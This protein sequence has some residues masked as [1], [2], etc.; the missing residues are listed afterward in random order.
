MCKEEPAKVRKEEESSH[1]PGKEEEKGK[2]QL[3]C[4]TNAESSD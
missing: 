3:L 2:K 4:V 1:D